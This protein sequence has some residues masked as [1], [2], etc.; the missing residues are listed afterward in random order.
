MSQASC[1]PQILFKARYNLVSTI[2]CSYHACGLRL[3]GVQQLRIVNPTHRTG[4]GDFCALPSK[5]N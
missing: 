4:N 1:G 5:L 3:L 2:E